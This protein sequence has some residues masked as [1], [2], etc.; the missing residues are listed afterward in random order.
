ML[1]LLELVSLF[2]CFEI[3]LWIISHFFT[4]KMGRRE[5]SNDNSERKVN[6]GHKIVREESCKYC[7]TF[8]LSYNIVMI[9]GEAVN[10]FWIQ[11]V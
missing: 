3:F 7:H 5:E 2:L 8:P 4:G 6:R 11:C 10:H 9:W 1:M